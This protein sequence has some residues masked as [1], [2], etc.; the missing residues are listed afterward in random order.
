MI[1]NIKSTLIPNDSHAFFTNK[2]INSDKYPLPLD[3]SFSKY[4]DRKKTK[5]NRQLAS[6]SLKF[7][8]KKVCYLNQVHSSKVL[9]VKSASGQLNKPA[10]GMVTNVHNLGL[11]ILTADCAPVL[12]FDPVAKVIGAAHAGWRGAVNGVLENTVDAML[13]IG[14]AKKNIAVAIGPC[15]SKNNYEVGKDL[16]DMLI[17]ND[18]KNDKYFYH[19]LKDKFLFD[20]SGFITGKLINY[21]I[22]T[23][24]AVNIC[25]YQ[26]KNNLHSYRHAQH[27]DYANHCR[28][29]SLI[30]L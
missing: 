20:L 15:I 2:A 12:F 28:N 3:F 5:S 14:A 9:F 6:A 24:I 29:M 4:Q 23:V 7:D 22:E 18:K 13:T 19:K 8:E 11:A 16:R 10:D 26:E 27:N 17:S 21:N 25:T 1:K 30:K